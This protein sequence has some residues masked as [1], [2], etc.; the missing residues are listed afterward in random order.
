MDVRGEPGDPLSVQPTDQGGRRFGS[1]AS[2]LVGWIDDPRDLGQRVLALGLH[3]G[4]DEPDERAAV[5]PPRDPAA[6][7]TSLAELLALPPETRKARGTL[8]LHALSTFDIRAALPR[9]YEVYRAAL[10]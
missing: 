2:A 6:F 10:R 5:V 1:E 9:W 3:G 8:G 7:A 4:L